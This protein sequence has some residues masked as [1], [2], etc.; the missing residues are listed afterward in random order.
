[1]WKRA[2]DKNFAHEVD[3]CMCNLIFEAERSYS[4][5]QSD[6]ILELLHWAAGE[7]C[8]PSFNSMGNRPSLGSSKKE[9][10]THAFCLLPTEPVSIHWSRNKRQWCQAPIYTGVSCPLSLGAK[11]L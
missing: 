4:L 10:I 7:L 9:S 3:T 11:R 6:L 1:M 2:S 5:K 8:Y